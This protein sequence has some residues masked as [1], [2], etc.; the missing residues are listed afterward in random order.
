MKDGYYLLPG[1]VKSRSSAS[2]ADKTSGIRSIL[3]GRV[4][5]ISFLEERR[6]LRRTPVRR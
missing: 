4:V 1:G 3:F 5:F 2:H 6:D